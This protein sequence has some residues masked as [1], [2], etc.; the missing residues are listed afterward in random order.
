MTERSHVTT[1]IYHVATQL[2]VSGRF[3]GTMDGDMLR[4][5]KAFPFHGAYYGLYQ[6]DVPVAARGEFQT[7]ASQSNIAI[8]FA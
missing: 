5:L 6:V 8:T 4:T 2:D 7:T 1:Y 3:I